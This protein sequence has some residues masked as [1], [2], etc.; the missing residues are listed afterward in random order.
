MEALKEE[1]AIEKIMLLQGSHG[2]FEKS[3]R[4]ACTAKSIPLQQVPREALY[5]FTKSNN[6]QGVVA[7]IAPIEYQDLK[8]LLP[9]ILAQEKKPLFVMLDRVT[10]IRNLGA[11]ARSAELLGADAMIISAKHRARIDEEAIKASAGALLK[12]AVCRESSLSQ[13]V[14]TLQAHGIRIA[15]ADVHQGM[16]INE[17][18]FTQPVAILLGA[19]DEGVHPELLKKADERFQIPQSGTIDSFN[20][21]VAAGITLYEV[22]RQRN[23]V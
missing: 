1:W 15:V 22:F 17:V 12:L 3:I 10:D 2:E 21:S 20:V 16:R 13:A 18:D 8:G 9:F 7:L 11:I 14:D 6:H 23:L 5:K 19:E 4:E